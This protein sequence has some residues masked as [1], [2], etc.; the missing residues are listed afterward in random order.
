M[1]GVP[2][3]KKAEE[4]EEVKFEAIT[5]DTLRNE[6]AF[7]KVMKKHQKDLEALRKKHQK[8][9]AIMQKNQC[10]AFDKLVKGKGK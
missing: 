1:P 2:S 3:S 4:K 7:L 9:R 6:K 8:D 5:A 10:L